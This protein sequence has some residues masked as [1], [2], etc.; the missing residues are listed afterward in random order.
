MNSPNA[1][2]T[3][4]LYR[5]VYYSDSFLTLFLRKSSPKKAKSCSLYPA[6]HYIKVYN[7]ESELYFIQVEE[8]L[9]QTKR[10]RFYKHF[11]YGKNEK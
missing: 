11:A 8:V 6:V 7:S 2:Q 9:K 5:A 4:S 1:S 10:S 3:R